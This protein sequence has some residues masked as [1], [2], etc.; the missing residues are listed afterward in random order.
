M[1]DH[2]F[3]RRLDELS[4]QA[5]LMAANAFRSGEATVVL[6][7]GREL[8][9]LHD[10]S[11]GELEEAWSGLVLDCGPGCSSCCHVRVDVTVPEAA[12]IAVRIR[13]LGE[14]ARRHVIARLRRLA[15]RPGVK[16]HSWWLKNGVAC[17]LLLND[18]CMVYADR[19]IQ[20]RAC[21]STS[22]AACRAGLEARDGSHVVTLARGPRLLAR[23]LFDG[24]LQGMEDCGLKA[25]AWDLVSAL[26]AILLELD[27]LD[28]RLPGSPAHKGTRS[29]GRSAPG[30]KNGRPACRP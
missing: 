27:A 12:L 17:P 28:Q 5:R 11:I 18:L 24:V 1:L 29:A 26:N 20:C 6:R 3:T 15:T 16:R 21:L 10:R 8:L 7:L 2:R 30:P 9:D 4:A 22:A 25:G 13:R 19:P 14:P 23:A